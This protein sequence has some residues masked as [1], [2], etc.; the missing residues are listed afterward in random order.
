MYQNEVLVHPPQIDA[1]QERPRTA[2]ADGGER[3]GGRSA[4]AVRRDVREAEHRTEDL[5]E[6]SDHK[7][8]GRR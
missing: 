5:R 4:A 8:T 3:E 6:G 7:R 1:L 2:E